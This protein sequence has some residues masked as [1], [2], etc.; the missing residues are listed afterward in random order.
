MTDLIKP[1]G[2]QAEIFSAIISCQSAFCNPYFEPMRAHILALSAKL[3]FSYV[4]RIGYIANISSFLSTSLIT[5]TKKIKLGWF[6]MISSWQIC[7]VCL[8]SCY[9]QVLG[10]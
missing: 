6:N 5:L 2:I 7:V 9:P 4:L 3:Y 1:S 8:L 10:N